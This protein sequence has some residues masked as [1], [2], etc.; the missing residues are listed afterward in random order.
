MNPTVSLLVNYQNFDGTPEDLF[1]IRR[2]D[3]PV[4]PTP[5]LAGPE[6]ARRR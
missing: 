6:S 3:V 5:L 4:N 2:R 1:E